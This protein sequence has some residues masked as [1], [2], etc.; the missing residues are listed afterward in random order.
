LHCWALTWCVPSRYERELTDARLSGRPLYAEV[1]QMFD[2]LDQDESG[3]RGPLARACLLLR[4]Q[5]KGVG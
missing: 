3:A 4:G 1:R 5:R 2:E